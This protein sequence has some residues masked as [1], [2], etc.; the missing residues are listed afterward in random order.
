MMVHLLRDAPSDDFGQLSL[1]GDLDAGVF[2][3]EGNRHA[4]DFGA[5][6]ALPLDLV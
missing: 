2:I 6:V 3:G 1:E 4:L 5:M